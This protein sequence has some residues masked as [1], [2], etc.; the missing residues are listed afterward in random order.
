MICEIR[1][2]LTSA[3]IMEHIADFHK[4]FLGTLR[5]KRRQLRG[6]SGGRP[7]KPE[8]SGEGLRRPLGT[9]GPAYM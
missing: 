9:Q 5:G 4:K 6:I 2:V 3:T 1:V 7:A 8:V